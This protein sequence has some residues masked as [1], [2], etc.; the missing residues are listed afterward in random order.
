MPETVA[1]HVVE[2][3]LDYKLG[4]KWLPFAAALGAPPTRTA[5]CFAPEPGR[6][7]KLFQFSC[8]SG[9]VRVGYRRGKPHVVEFAISIE[10]SDQQRTDLSALVPIAEPAD[11]AIRRP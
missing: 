10:K 9:P 2:S 8:Q 5:R 6:A 11:N 4:P 7:A 1:C 3:H